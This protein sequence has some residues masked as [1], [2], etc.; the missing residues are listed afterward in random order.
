[1]QF[2]TK[3]INPFPFFEYG[4][5]YYDSKEQLQKPQKIIHIYLIT[6]L[7]FQDKFICQAQE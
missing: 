3:G 1:M 7:S 4:N 2:V 5:L 6:E